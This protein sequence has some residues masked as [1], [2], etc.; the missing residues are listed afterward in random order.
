[1][2]MRNGY[3]LNYMVSILHHL[4]DEAGYNIPTAF[5]PPN[6]PPYRYPLVPYPYPYTHYPDLGNTSYEGGEYRAPGDA[7]L[8]TGATQSYEGNSIILS[9]GYEIEGS[10]RGVHD[11]DDDDDD[12]MNDLF[13]HSEDC[14]PSDDDMDD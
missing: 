7:Y 12:D 9:S 8:F 11:D 3:I 1:M 10:S 6:V 14:M 5:D 13:V 4:A 2:F